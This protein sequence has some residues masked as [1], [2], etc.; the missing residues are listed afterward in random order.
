[1]HCLLN[2][3]FNPAA[4]TADASLFVNLFGIKLVL[5]SHFLVNDYL[6]KYF[7]Q[8]ELTGVNSDSFLESHHVCS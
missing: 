6:S 2:F 8:L 7:Y 1:M 3:S 4:G 5:L